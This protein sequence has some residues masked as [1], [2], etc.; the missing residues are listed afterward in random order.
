MIVVARFDVVNFTRTYVYM[1]FQWIWLA[2][3][4]LWKHWT[5]RSS[6]KRM[7]KTTELKKT[8]VNYI[9]NETF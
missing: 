1:M 8:V 2:A 3:R 4:D 9:T 7:T 5:R 6:E